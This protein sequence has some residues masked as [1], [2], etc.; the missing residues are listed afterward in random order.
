MANQSNQPSSNPL[1][2]YTVLYLTSIRHKDMIIP[3]TLSIIVSNS[4]HSDLSSSKYTARASPQK[5]A[6]SEEAKEET[7]Y[8][9]S[10]ISEQDLL[11]PKRSHPSHSGLGRSLQW[12]VDACPQLNE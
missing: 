9:F 4:S 2:Y 7:E 3:G 8:L 10:L 12:M 5:A 1:L 6:S 11:F